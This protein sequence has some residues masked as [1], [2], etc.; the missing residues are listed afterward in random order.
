[1]GEKA[2]ESSLKT[3]GKTPVEILVLLKENPALSIPE[4]AERIG[5]S[6]SA[7]ERAIRKLRQ[8]GILRRVGPDKGGHWEVGE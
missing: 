1:L 7:V 2:G 8:Q 4:L 5:K 6:E 3:P